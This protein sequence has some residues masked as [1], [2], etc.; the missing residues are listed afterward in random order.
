MGGR[1]SRA[2]E[3]KLPGTGQHTIIKI[4]LPNVQLE[5]N[6]VCKSHSSKRRTIQVLN[7][8][9]EPQAPRLVQV[10]WHSTAEPRSLLNLPFF[11]FF[12]KIKSKH[13][14]KIAAK[15][16]A[17]DHDEGPRP[18]FWMASSAILYTW[19]MAVH[20]GTLSPC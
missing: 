15:L 4:W 2:S 10:H 13:I 5:N 16:V 19:F 9:S 17:C 7:S 6:H 20:T 18:R 8:G 12:V 3:N 14:Q 11:F 1:V